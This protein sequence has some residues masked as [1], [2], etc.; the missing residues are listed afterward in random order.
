M[1]R[2][3]WCLIPAKSSK[4]NGLAMD[5]CRP[6]RFQILENLSR[7]SFAVD[8]FLQKNFRAARPEVGQDGNQP[9]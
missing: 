6:V 3:P 9:C 7:C 8:P 5:T 1:D 2:R 4:R